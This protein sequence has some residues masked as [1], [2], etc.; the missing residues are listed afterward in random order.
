MSRIKECFVSRYESGVLVNFDYKQL[1]VVALAVLSQDP[2][3]MH[4]LRSGVDMHTKYA[5]KIFGKC[6]DILRTYIKRMTFQLQYGATAHGMS[7]SLGLEKRICQ[8]FIDEYF[9]RYPLVKSWQEDQI[10]AVEGSAVPDPESKAFPLKM[11]TI[12]SPTGRL[13]TYRQDVVQRKNWRT[14]ITET[15]GEFKPTQIKNYPV[16]GIAT[17]DLVPLMCGILNKF[18]LTNDIFSILLINTVHD[19]IMLD[20]DLGIMEEATFYKHMSDIK[21]LLE[22]APAAMKDFY[23]FDWNMPTPVDAECGPSWAELRHLHL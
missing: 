11:S 1:E 2:T 8:K 17:G 3:L 5:M 21:N 4:D 20:V 6:N 10:R 13:Y 22:N 9:E 19:S 18:L 14:G 15:R 12:Q 23:G 7:K 16:Q